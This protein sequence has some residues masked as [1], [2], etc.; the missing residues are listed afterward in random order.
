MEL[1][2][3]EQFEIPNER[4]E[5]IVPWL[6]DGLNLNAVYWNAGVAGITLPQ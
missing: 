5:D 2:S 6:T 3:Y 1:A 4:I